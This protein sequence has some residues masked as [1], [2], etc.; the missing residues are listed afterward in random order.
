[1]I[2]FLALNADKSA[3]MAGAAS[4]VSIVALFVFFAVGGVFGPINDS[5]SVFQFLFLIPIAL[6]LYRILAPHSRALSLG[7]TAVGIAAMLVFA[8]LQ[9]LLVFG[10]VRFEQT[11]KPVLILSGIVGLW[12]LSTSILSITRGAL[13]AGLAWVGVVAGVSSVLVL[14]GF[15]IGG[16]EHPLAAVGFLAGGVA[17]PVWAFWMGKFLAASHAP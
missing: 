11:L 2:D 16:Q 12:W 1:M 4:I 17:I 8:V 6:A 9:A 13:P 3:Y 15:W 14:V 7:A 5:A 10:Y